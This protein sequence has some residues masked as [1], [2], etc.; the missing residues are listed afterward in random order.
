MNEL[1]DI[2]NITDLIQQIG[3][4][5]TVDPRIALQRSLEEVVEATLDASCESKHTRRSYQEGIGLFIDYLDQKYGKR[6]PV[7]WRP[8]VF[9]DF[10]GRRK[11]WTF[12][13]PAAIL[14]FVD[15][16]V[17]DGFRQELIT[18]GNA[19]STINLREAAV[20]SF[21]S[22]AYRDGIL[23]PDQARSMNITAFRPRRKRSQKIVGRRLTAFEVRA[24][25]EAV[26]V[27]THKGKRDLAILDM[28]L[29]L[30][31]RREEITTITMKSFVKDR[32]NWYLRITGKGRK[33]RKLKLP[34]K[35][36][37]G[38]LKQWLDNSNLELGKG[39]APLFGWAAKKRRSCAISTSTITRIVQKYGYEADIA[40]LDGAGR[41]APHDLRRTAARTAYDKGASLLQVQKM[42][43]HAKPETTQRYIG[44][45]D[46]ADTAM[47]Y[48]S[49]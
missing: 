22:I 15:A 34:Q 2:G 9:I 28:M 41:L 48:I 7:Q 40:P 8:F 25:R 18:K 38:S 3:Q 10:V 12:N 33:E 23:T 5:S 14:R 13:A 29:F 1:L 49:Y 6:L 16:S 45:L 20:N 4:L 31:L 44:S 35:M 32:G 46:D 27:S 26:D 19:I 11:R 24:L 47:D 43:G 30:G 39:E 17:L 36:L 42:L 21:L 37:L